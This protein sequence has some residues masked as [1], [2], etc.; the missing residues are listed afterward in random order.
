MN[1]KY[2]YHFSYQ[3]G[4]LALASCIYK[5]MFNKEKLEKFILSDNDID[6][7]SSVFLHFKVT[8]LIEGTSLNDLLDKITSLDYHDWYL[9]M[10]HYDKNINYQKRMEITKKIA[11]ALKNEGNIKNPKLQLQWFTFSGIWYLGILERNP[12]TYK[13][14]IAKP[15]QYS[16]ALSVRLAHQII[17]LTTYLPNNSIIDPCCGIG[18]VVIE[19]LIAKKNIVGCEINEQIKN[20]ALRNLQH[21]NLPNR[22][23]CQ[24]MLEINE[25]F[26]IAIIDI[27]YGLYNTFEKQQQL[28]LLTKAITICRYLILIS[29]SDFDD[30]L[31]QHNASIFIKTSTTK[32]KFT[33]QITIFQTPQINHKD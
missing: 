29:I 13:L 24:D 17:Q 28:A 2:F 6:V 9:N 27:P 14:R 18:T 33:R 20:N 21:F 26:D 19:G 4:E 23:F 30:Y 32:A 10:W 12:Y 22:I 8:V 3:D 7:N 1:K 31:I 25:L 16:N 11:L 15:Y 5:L